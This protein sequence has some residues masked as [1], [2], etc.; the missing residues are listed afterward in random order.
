MRVAVTA[1]IWGG[2]AFQQVAEEARDAGYA[3][4][5]GVGDLAGNVALARGVLADAGLEV[6][7]GRFFANW[8][9]EMYQEIE[10]NQLQRAAE[11]YADLGAQYL[12]TSSRPVPERMLTAGHVTSQR[13]DGLLDYQWTQLADSLTQ[14]AYVTAR[15][16]ELPLLFRNQLGSYVENG[17][18]LDQ[19]IGMT[20]PDNLRLAPDI[21]YLAYAGLDPLAFVRAH[22]ERIAYVTLK[23]LDAD[24]HEQHIRARG[25]LEEFWNWGKAMW[26]WRA[27]SA[28]CESRSSTAGWPWDTTGRDAIRRPACRFRAITWSVWGSNSKRTWHDEGH[29]TPRRAGRRRRRDRAGGAERLRRFDGPSLATQFHSPG[30]RVALGRQHLPGPGSGDLE[31]P[32]HP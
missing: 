16:F 4:I 1:T 15:D 3:G 32:P 22:S 13:Q 23:D 31:A 11:F 9:A 14:A 18:E 7:A 30:Q 21:G 17:D 27:S 26:T 8:F 24:L 10:F 29:R 25:S 2:T 12:I 6:T 5:E 20:D 19:L 28:C